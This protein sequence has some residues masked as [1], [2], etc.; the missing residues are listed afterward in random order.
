MGVL[1]VYKANSTGI[2]PPA[3]TSHRIVVVFFCYIR[4]DNHNAMTV[5]IKA[6]F[7]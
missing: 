6:S 1:F 5:K 2:A 7:K 3:F 4:E